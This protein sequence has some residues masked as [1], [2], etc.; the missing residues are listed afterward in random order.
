M[1][2][3]SLIEEV[4]AQFPGDDLEGRLFFHD[5]TIFYFNAVK[6]DSERKPIVYCS[7]QCLSKYLEVSRPYLGVF[8]KIKSY[9]CYF[10]T[11]T[12]QEW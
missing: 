8:H 6:S 11:G 7:E 3:P 12:Q 5:H 1:A 10:T 4:F 9:I 2:P